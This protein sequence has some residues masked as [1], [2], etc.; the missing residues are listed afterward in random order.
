VPSGTSWL[1]YG[2]N[3]YTGRRIAEEAVRRGMRPVLA[4]RDRAKIG[5]LATLLGCEARDFGLTDTA[6]IVRQLEG[7]FAVLHCAGP[8]SA[9]A[10]PM[11]DACL[12]SGSHYL[13]ITGEIDVIEHAAAQNER[14]REAGVSLIPAVGFDV[15][16]S[17]CLAA[18]LHERLHT[19][20]QLCLA[21]SGTGS[22]SRG[23]ARTMLEN[24]PRGGRV[25]RDGKVTRVPL[26]WKSKEIP[27]RSGTRTAVTI[28]W[29]DVASAWRS[30]G[31]PN[32]EVYLAVDA[33]QIAWMRRLRPFVG[34]LRLPWPEPI[35]QSMLRR[36]MLG[37]G[38][39]EAGVGQASF[40]GHVE[41]AEGK[42]AEA[43][44]ETLDG[45]SLTVETALACVKKVLDGRAE[46][47]FFT[48]SQAFGADFILSM[49]KTDVQWAG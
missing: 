38:Q 14:A 8:F 46:P 28:P 7:V 31:I 39:P 44:L 23:T 12:A 22:I 41:D 35:I 32:I 40:W 33:S 48:P 4:G 42:T 13:D 36:F 47:G 26:A 37:G 11:M 5:E 49:P 34:L 15:V 45:Y 19:A 25:R 1:L 20:V 17:D 27:F 16:P 43:T 2:A 30:T 3:G 18:M 29:G 10:A 24:L 9:T 6:E 21:F